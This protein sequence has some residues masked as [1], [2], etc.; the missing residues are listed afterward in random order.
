MS[1][2]TNIANTLSLEVLGKI[3]LCYFQNNV[4]FF[5]CIFTFGYEEYAVST[6]MF[7]VTF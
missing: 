1:Q 5:F 3:N 7:T 6:F 2:F 4:D